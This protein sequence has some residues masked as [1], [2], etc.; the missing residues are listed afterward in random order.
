[1]TNLAE[2]ATNDDRDADDG[3]TVRIPS[4]GSDATSAVKDDGHR[5]DD[6]SAGSQHDDAALDGW[7]AE[8]SSRETSRASDALVEIEGLVDVIVVDPS[9]TSVQDSGLE[10]LWFRLD[11]DFVTTA[12]VPV[13]P[14]T[15]KHARK[16]A[17]DLARVGAAIS[18]QSIFVVSALDVNAVGAVKVAEA[19]RRPDDTRTIVVADAPSKSTASIPIVRSAARTVLLVEL[20][21]SLVDATERNVEIIGTDR[22]AGI[23]CVQPPTMRRFR[24]RSR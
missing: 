22:V 1:M 15:S 12:I 10:S 24:R 20:R 4:W 17:I 18:Q 13:P 5:D 16:V 3:A 14:M 2:N 9:N 7:M 21:R 23:V 8:L 11:D 6:P 19:I